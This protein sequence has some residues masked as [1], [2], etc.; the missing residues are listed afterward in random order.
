MVYEDDYVLDF[1]VCSDFGFE[2]LQ[3]IC[4]GR[5]VIKFWEGQVSLQAGHGWF[6]ICT[7]D[8][9]VAFLINVREDWSLTEDKRRGDFPVLFLMVFLFLN[10]LLYCLTLYLHNYQVQVLQS[11]FFIFG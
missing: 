5:K 8:G 11:L 1:W 6:V 3:D 4:N 2:G 10:Q 7:K 9:S